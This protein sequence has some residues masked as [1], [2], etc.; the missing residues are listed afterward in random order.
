MK[1][2]IKIFLLSAFI[3]FGSVLINSGCS[4]S[5]K[6]RRAKRRIIHTDNTKMGKNKVFFSKKYR[7]R[8]KRSRRKRG[9]GGGGNN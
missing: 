5:Y 4:S 2:L 8:L 3:V 6:T 9:L 7:R 1:G